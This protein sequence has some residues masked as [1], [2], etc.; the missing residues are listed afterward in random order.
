[1]VNIFWVKFSVSSAW[2]PKALVV[3]LTIL[4][5]SNYFTW[6]A[7][8]CLSLKAVLEVSGSILLFCSTLTVKGDITQRKHASRSCMSESWEIGSPSIIGRI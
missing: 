1:M 3:A 5:P 4:H 2:F 6:A 8:G 7:F